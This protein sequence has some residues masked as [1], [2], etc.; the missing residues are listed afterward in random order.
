MMSRLLIA[1]VLRMS[2]WIS[3]ERLFKLGDKLSQSSK[4]LHGQN[5]KSMKRDDEGLSSISTRN[6]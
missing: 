4:K 6:T 1:T 5:P 2:I 3:A